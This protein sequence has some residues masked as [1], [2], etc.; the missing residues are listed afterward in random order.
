MNY[1]TLQELVK[2]K[3]IKENKKKSTSNDPSLNTTRSSSLDLGFDELHIHFDQ[4]LIPAQNQNKK[5]LCQV[6]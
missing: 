1:N 3:K 4:L 6:A 5:K 2:L